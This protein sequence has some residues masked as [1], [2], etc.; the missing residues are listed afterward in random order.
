MATGSSNRRDD[1]YARG[2][3]QLQEVEE[4]ILMEEENEPETVYNE[5]HQLY[6]TFITNRGN[7][8]R[9]IPADI[10]QWL[11]SYNVSDAADIVR[12]TVRA[13]NPSNSDADPVFEACCSIN[14]GFMF[15]T[16]MNRGGWST[17]NIYAANHPPRLR[18][19]MSEW[20]YHTWEFAAKRSGRTG[21]LLPPLSR[22]VI[23]NINNVQLSGA[24]E[25]LKLKT[26][27][28][29]GELFPDDNES[30][31]VTFF[32]MG[33]VRAIARAL[34]S[35]SK[36]FLRHYPT[37]IAWRS[38]G[39]SYV[40]EG[41][42]GKDIQLDDRFLIICLAPLVLS[43]ER[44]KEEMKRMAAAQAAAKSTGQRRQQ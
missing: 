14:Q 31:F 5:S 39:Q 11:Q 29:D 30:P 15:I 41:H 23:A 38:G 20:I 42:G 10:V 2:L 33:L 44:K 28:N 4:T 25:D 18:V 35:M 19:Y 32:G 27:R 3:A 7:L 13:K 9:G 12:I 43:A 21:E 22:V 24:I 16:Y 17:D 36:S 40:G 37:R 1:L 26:E 8:P 6:E 34:F